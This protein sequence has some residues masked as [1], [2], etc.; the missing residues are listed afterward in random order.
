MQE[1]EINGIIVGTCIVDQRACL[2]V[3]C[4][5]FSLSLISLSPFGL[6]FQNQMLGSFDLVISYSS[7]SG[8]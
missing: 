2:I 7:L 5:I 1:D 6:Y 4:P 3:Y 8:L